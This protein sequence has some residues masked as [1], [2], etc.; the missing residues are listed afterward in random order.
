MPVPVIFAVLAAGLVLLALDRKRR[1]SL[2][3]IAAGLVMLFLLSIPGLSGSAL[4][5]LEAAHPRL[6]EPPPADWII[7]LGGGVLYH[8]DRPAEARLGEASLL[9]IT[10]GIRL[11]RELPGAGLIVC[12]SGTAGVMAE[13]AEERGVD[14]GRIVVLENPRNT[15]EEA[16]EVSRIIGSGEEAILVTSAFHMRRAA[17]L[18]NGRG[19]PVIPSP[20]GHMAEVVSSS[21][22]LS[23]YLPRAENIA[24][25]ETVLN[26]KLG[27]A[28][29]RLRGWL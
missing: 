26:E 17:A 6:D 16:L 5:R 13:V 21:T 3:L 19:M 23:K 11:A 27:L 7:V 22:Y 12:G 14:R 18:F 15:Y 1:L 24:F 2:Y 4:A 28:W 29:A 10:E 8:D 9:R 20:A 25:A